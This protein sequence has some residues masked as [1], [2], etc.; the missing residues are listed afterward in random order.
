MRASALVG[1]LGLLCGLT[2]ST[3]AAHAQEHA[4]AVRT[5]GKFYY[6]PVGFPTTFKR[7]GT[8]HTRVWYMERS[9]ERVLLE[10]FY[11]VAGKPVEQPQGGVS[12]RWLNPF[13]GR[14]QNSNRSD[15]WGDFWLDLAPQGRQIVMTPGYWYHVDVQI[16]FSNTAPTGL[17][18]VLPEVL[19]NYQMINA[20][21]QPVPDILDLANG[22]NSLRLH[23]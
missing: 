18:T 16:T 7:G 6:A 13:T 1:T 8:I 2:L 19:G 12:V 17:W 15:R 5:V 21:G 23:R 10:S 4:P 20:H 3:P 11:M 9:P 14:W 22:V